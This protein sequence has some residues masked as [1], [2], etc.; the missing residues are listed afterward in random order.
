ML[1]LLTKDNAP[2][3][4][5]LL[6]YPTDEFRILWAANVKLQLEGFFFFGPT[7]LSAVILSSSRPH[8]IVKSLY[9]FGLTTLIVSHHHNF[10]IF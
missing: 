6:R 4:V 9:C 1:L 3:R 2:C 7:Y 5:C 8:L 10:F